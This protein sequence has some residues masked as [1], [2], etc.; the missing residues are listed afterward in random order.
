MVFSWRCLLPQTATTPVHLTRSSHAISYVA[1]TNTI[2][3]YGGENQPRIPV[4]NVLYSFSLS[5]PAAGWAPVNLASSSSVCPPERIAP[6]M[7]AMDKTLYVMGGRQGIT[8]DEGPLDDLWAFDTQSKTWTCV[9]EHTEEKGGPSK[10]SFHQMVGFE[11]KLYVFGGC[12]AKGRMRDLYAFDIGKGTWEALPS[13]EEMKGRGGAAVTAVDGKVLLLGGFAGEEARDMWAFDLE[14]KEWEDW[15]S[16]STGL[17]PR[18]VFGLQ[19]VQGGK[20]L[21]LFGGEVDPSSAGHMGAGGFAGDTLLFSLT[22]KTQGFTSPLP[23]SP[24]SPSPSPR[25]WY[26]HCVTKE[27]SVVVV[28]GLAPDNSRL[29]DVW[30]LEEEGK[31]GGGK[32]EL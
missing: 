22:D 7:V 17:E 24:P 25:G 27:G 1:A 28:G 20:S 14:K 29:G 8:M 5:D 13:K 32:E 21:V 16:Y 31:E 30:V 23:S 9:M 26:G 10:R 4:D 11:G 15:S 2:Y 12:G 19:P 3:L 6:G 18:S